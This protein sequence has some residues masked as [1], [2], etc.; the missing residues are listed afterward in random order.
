MLD[1]TVDLLLRDGA[2]GLNVKAIMLE[3]GVLRTA[4]YRR[5]DTAH[6]AVLGMLSRL[7]GYMVDSS[8]DWLADPDAI[9]YPAVVEPNLVQ[10]GRALA[11]HAP[12]ICAIVDAAGRTTGS[13]ERGATG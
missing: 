2:A 10:N 8:V 7:L 1:A 3:A 13:G 5:F 4:F 11:P 6:D 12:L 9:G